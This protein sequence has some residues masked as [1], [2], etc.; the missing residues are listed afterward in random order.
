MLEVKASVSVQ[1]NLVAASLIGKAWI[2][3][4]QAVDI[5]RRYLAGIERTTVPLLPGSPFHGY[6]DLCITNNPI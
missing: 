1:V 6:V 2:C 3:S 5:G 4:V